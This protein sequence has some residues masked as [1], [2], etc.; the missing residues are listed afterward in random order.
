MNLKIVGVFAALLLLLNGCDGRP[1]HPLRIAVNPWVGFTPVVY[2]QEQGWLEGVDVRFVWVVGLEENVKLYR[3]GLVDGFAATQYEF[4][5]L[6]HAG[7]VKPYYLFDR[8][9]GADVILGS[10][11]V[12]T[13]AKEGKIDVYLEIT[14]LN[15]D[16]LHA[17]A[18]QYGVDEAHFELH[19][20]D[21]E[22]LLHIPCSGRPTIIVA[23][24]PYATAI[25]NGGCTR[26]ASTRELENIRVIDALWI[27]TDQAEMYAKTVRRLGKIFDRAIEKLKEDPKAYYD[28]VKGSLE[29]Q[30]YDEFIR[31]LEGI[32]W[33]NRNPAEVKAYLQKSRIP[34]DGLAP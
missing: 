5:S 10:Q 31:S 7:T 2:A 25:E 4:Y 8:S 30:D 12:E 16:L 11:S 22:S 15:S 6:K 3:Q 19:S 20:S 32:A 23:Y 17:F 14:G 33:I 24:E 21:P 29:G 9:A 1:H 27:S 13:L 26:I 34:T 28:V 18:Q